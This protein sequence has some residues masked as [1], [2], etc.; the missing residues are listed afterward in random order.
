M[1]DTALASIIV[2]SIGT[3]GTVLVALIHR[4]MKSNANDH[5]NVRSM[6]DMVHGDIKRVDSNLDRLDGHV[7][8]IEDKIDGHIGWH[9][10]EK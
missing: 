7:Q 4:F 1:S 5:S 3:V 6:L 2:A 10:E 9:L 8:R